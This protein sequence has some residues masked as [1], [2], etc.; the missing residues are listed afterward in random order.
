MKRNG[1]KHC[2]GLIIRIDGQWEHVSTDK[3]HPGLPPEPQR[4]LTAED[5]ERIGKNATK[6][7]PA[8]LRNGPQRY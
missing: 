2:G 8:V 7:G 3:L 4:V 6:N 5:I 1:C